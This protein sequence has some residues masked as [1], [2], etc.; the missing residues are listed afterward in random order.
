MTAFSKYE[1]MAPKWDTPVII[2][3]HINGAR[4]KAMNPNLPVGHD[5]LVAEAI[6][7]FDAG[8][9]AVHAHN[10][11]YSLKGE[12][13]ADDYLKTWDRVFEKYPD[14][15][16]YG[17]TCAVGMLTPEE[18]GLEHVGILHDKRK[19]KL[20]VI[21]NGVVN[22]GR[23]IDDEG[24]ISG[25]THGYGYD[26]LNAQ[27]KM[28]REKGMGI[29]FSVFE[30]GFMRLA[31]HYE[32][33]GLLPKGSTLDLYL[34]GDYGLISMDGANT[35]GMPASLETLYYYMYMME[36]SRMPWFVSIWGAPSEDEIPIMRR[37]I[38]LGGHLK[39]GLE[40]HFDPNKKPTNLELLKQAQDI[41]KDVGRPIAARGE[42]LKI[43]GF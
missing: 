3:A 42:L 9:C 41:A 12:A 34:M 10:T 18:H 7:C 15:V 13:A 37:V 31:L 32:K 17:S 30:P 35:A 26:R 38:E 16:M 11:N 33:R 24:Y 25:L 21:D 2:E 39:V 43:Y 28:C 27:V 6:K 29:I 4:T 20:C 23:T 19:I 36:E 22:L 14:G 1:N 8:A 5:E 40:M